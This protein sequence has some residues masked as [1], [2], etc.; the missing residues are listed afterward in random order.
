MP[1]GAKLGFILGHLGAS[2]DACWAKGRVQGFGWAFCW[3]IWGVGHMHS[4]LQAPYCARL[5]LKTFSGPLHFP[6]TVIEFSL[7]ISET[8]I[9]LLAI[10]QVSTSFCIHGFLGGRVCGT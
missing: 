1:F 8:G 10:K 5:C 9:F 7:L 3:A 6:P 4:C 2:M